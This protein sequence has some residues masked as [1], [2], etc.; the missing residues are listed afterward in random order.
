MKLLYIITQ[1]NLGK[2]KSSEYLKVFAEQNFRGDLSLLNAPSESSS[3][4]NKNKM[5]EFATVVGDSCLML[6][7]MKAQME[8][9]TPEVNE[10]LT[11]NS[12][13]P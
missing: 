12:N 6:M 1:K 9:L 10:L 4:E 7:L 11:K 3:Y 2:I 5:N 8:K 13:I